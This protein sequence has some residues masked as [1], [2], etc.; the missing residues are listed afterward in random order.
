[1]LLLSVLLPP[2]CALIDILEDWDQ[3]QLKQRAKNKGMMKIKINW[4][5]ED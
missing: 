5:M 2:P 4:K 1:M 3:L